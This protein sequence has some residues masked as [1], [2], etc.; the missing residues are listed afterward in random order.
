M[1]RTTY[2]APGV[3][4]EEIPSAHG[5]RRTRGDRR[6]RRGAAA[7]AERTTPVRVLETVA[8]PEVVTMNAW[9]DT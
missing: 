4:V 7:V 6:H 5:T 1:A 2:L 8:T 9:L 3:Y